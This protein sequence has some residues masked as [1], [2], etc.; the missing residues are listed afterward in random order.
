[1]FLIKSSLDSGGWLDTVARKSAGLN[2]GTAAEAFLLPVS[3]SGDD[4]GVGGSD[5]GCLVIGSSW[6]LSGSS[7]LLSGVLALAPEKDRNIFTRSI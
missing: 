7:W 6:L 4:A 5:E 1:M 2:L 3:G